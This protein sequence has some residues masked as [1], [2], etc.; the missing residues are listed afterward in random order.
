MY[1]QEM[2]LFEDAIVKQRDGDDD[3]DLL[4]DQLEGD[5]W[6]VSFAPVLSSVE[7]ATLHAMAADICLLVA[8]Q[9]VDSSDLQAQAQGGAVPLLQLR[10]QLVRRRML[11]R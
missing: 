10:C 6:D 3:L 5:N 7:C 2:A 4:A 8:A 1:D 11:Q 9:A